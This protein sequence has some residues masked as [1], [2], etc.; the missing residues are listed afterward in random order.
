[1]TYNDSLLPEAPTSVPLQA[2]PTG[3]PCAPRTSTALSPREAEALELIARGFSYADIARLQLV[4]VNTVCARIKSIYSKLGVHSKTQAVYEAAS[5]GLL[6]RER[7]LPALASKL[8]AL[9]P[10]N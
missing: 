4:S 1:M 10:V 9:R 6:P 8:G 3:A 7:P 5:S 2:A